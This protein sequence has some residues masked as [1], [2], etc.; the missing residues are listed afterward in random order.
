MNY[1]RGCLK[2]YFRHS[3]LVSESIQANNLHVTDSEMSSE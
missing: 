3:E 1:I 2:I